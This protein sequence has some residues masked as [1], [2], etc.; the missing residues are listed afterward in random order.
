VWLTSVVLGRQPDAVP[1]RFTWPALMVGGRVALHLAV[2]QLAVLFAAGGRIRALRQVHRTL[3]LAASRSLLGGSLIAVVFL[4]G[5]GLFG[6]ALYVVT[7][8][9]A[10][11]S[12]HGVWGGLV[13]PII[14]S[15]GV[16]ASVHYAALC[17]VR[18]VGHAART[19][20]DGA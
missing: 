3:A 4:F 9:L 20:L 11:A 17:A 18:I 19:A 16:G 15:V 8:G 1:E 10:L 2:A 13:V 5:G 6:Y 7:F 12:P 14:G